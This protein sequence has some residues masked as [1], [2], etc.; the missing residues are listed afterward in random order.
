[1][2]KKLHKS[3]IEIQSEN[4]RIKGELLTINFVSIHFSL[5]KYA[6]IKIYKTEKNY[7][8]QI[9]EP[10]NNKDWEFNFYKIDD[11]YDVTRFIKDKY[12][13]YKKYYNINESFDE[14]KN[15]NG[16]IEVIDSNKH[17]DLHNYRIY[18][19]E[20]ILKD[21]L[22]EVL[23]KSLNKIFNHSEFKFE[24]SL[25]HI[26]IYENKNTTISYYINLLD[27]DYYLIEFKPSEKSFYFICDG[28]LELKKLIKGQYEEFQ[29]KSQN[30]II[31]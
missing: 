10:K 24:H 13:V 5:M 27:D 28:I 20:G 8:I 9:F 19:D 29:K 26:T 14:L 16:S 18:M 25:K 4:R 15:E 21:R 3:I 1:M 12:K 17:T 2:V 11:I 23:L 7:F 31:K 22:I 30:Y 6:S